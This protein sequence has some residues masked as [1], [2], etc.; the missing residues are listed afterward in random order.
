MLHALAMMIGLSVLWLLLVPAWGLHDL[1]F[2]AAAAFACVIV[3]A[4]LG[5]VDRGGAFSHPFQLVALALGRTGA[6]L[7]GALSTLSAALFGGA[8]VKPALV[9]MKLRPSS[10]FARA[11]L[12]DLAGATPGAVTVDVDEEGLLVHVLNEDAVDAAELGHLE[13]RVTSALDGN[14]GAA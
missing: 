12:A 1:V 4:R 8:A 13:Q 3:A 6:V 9:R 2:A 7:R 10:D 11:V 14:R 5:G